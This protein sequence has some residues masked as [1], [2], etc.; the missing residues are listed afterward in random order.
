MYVYG[1][2]FKTLK[3]L[4]DMCPSFIVLKKRNYYCLSSKIVVNK[5]KGWR[6][7]QF[8]KNL[9]TAKKK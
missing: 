1:T 3:I 5:K 4:K 2:V 7:I 9:F 6:Q 8:Q